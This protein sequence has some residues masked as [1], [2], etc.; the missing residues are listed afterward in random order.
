MEIFNSV[1]GSLAT[2]SIWSFCACI[3]TSLAIG[4]FVTFMY[5][6]H[7]VSSKSFTATLAL[8]PVVVCVVI[9][10]VNGNIGAGV[11]VAGAFSLVRFRSAQG[12]AKE[13]GA[14]FLA[15]GAGLITGMGY[16]LFSAIFA[17][18]ASIAFW[19]FSSITFS[20]S[21]SSLKKTLTVTIPETLDY[22]HVFDD[23]FERFVRKHELTGVKTT[24][25]GSLFKLTY[26]IDLKDAACEK[27]LIDSV[28]ERNGNLEVMVNR[29][30][31]AKAE[32]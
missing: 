9:L 18:I 32:L 8:L 20:G 23:V 13:I 11:A 2:I 22:T 4:L 29:F 15:M 6:R 31:P 26:S 19:A 7:S 28:R 21:R 30:E 1:F 25:M 3:G 10:L 5:T 27:K 12:S 17:V 16:L 24:N 14:I